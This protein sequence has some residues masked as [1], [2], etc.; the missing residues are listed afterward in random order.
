MLGGNDGEEL[1]FIR[2]V[3]GVEAEKFAGAAHGIAD[4]KLFFEENDSV[5]A[6]PRQFVQGSGNAATRRIAHPANACASFA[7]ESLHERKHGACIRMQVGFQVEF[8]SSQ[9]YRDAV[10]SDGAREQNLVARAHRLRRD[11]DSGK[12]SPNS[13][14]A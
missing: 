9:Q 11:F 4:G 5:A 7:D 8:S 6:V 2:D 1:P 13:G 12:Q 10:I 14:R 3:Q